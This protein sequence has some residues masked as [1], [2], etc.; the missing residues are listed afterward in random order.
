M[1]QKLIKTD[2]SN[3][4][5]LI[6]RLTLGIIIFPHGAQKLFGLFGGYGFSGTMQYF[7][8]TAG[9]PWLVAFLIIIGESIGAIALMAGFATRFVSASF[10]IIMLGAIFLG[11]HINNGFFMNWYGTQAGEGYE[12]HLLVI[13]ISIAL[14]LSGSGKASVDAKL[15]KM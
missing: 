9:F 15:Q 14:L 6:T 10:I 5:A 12:Y 8:E 13:G 1:L 3:T 11:G 7:T 4:T 2:P